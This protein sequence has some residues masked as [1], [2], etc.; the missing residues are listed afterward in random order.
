M[1]AP[2]RLPLAVVLATVL[3]LLGEPTGPPRP[4]G[5]G[6]RRPSRPLRRRRRART[7]R[8]RLRGP[9]PG[10]DPRPHR[11][12]SP[13]TPSAVTPWAPAAPSSRRGPGPARGGRAVLRRRRPRLRGRCS[14][15]GCPHARLRPASLLKTLTGLLIA[16]DLPMDQT[17]VGTQDDANQEGTRVGIGPG[18]QY[19]D[20]PAP[21]RH[22]HGLGQRHRARALDPAHRL[23]ARDRR[24]DEPHRAK[25]IGALDTRAATPSGPRRAR[26]VVVGLRPRQHLPPGDGAPAVRAG[27]GH[28]ADRDPGL[29][30]EPPVAV[31]NDNK[32][33]GRYPGALGGKTGF[34]DDA[35]HTYI[36][37]A[38]RD[39][40][41]L[42]VVLMHGEQRPVLMY[43]QGI[44]LLDYGFSLPRDASVGQLTDSRPASHRR[45]GHGRLVTGRRG[46]LRRRHRL[47][48]HRHDELGGP[49]RDRRRRGPRPRSCWPPGCAGAEAAAMSG[50]RR[51]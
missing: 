8:R 33:L 21:R 4:L 7:G 6:A 32:L 24:P 36:G 17:V 43:E 26:P 45:P 39:G 5:A 50:W 28:D 23:G 12:R 41:R 20:P 37:S 40:R 30:P 25:Q 47:P 1:P 46:V 44:A 19:T 27:R 13:R 2:S 48:R 35:R 3:L 15:R 29:G 42:V 38:Q 14:P 34:T 11:C 9:A 16:Q 10:T 31:D 18:G 22:A 49:A 51:S